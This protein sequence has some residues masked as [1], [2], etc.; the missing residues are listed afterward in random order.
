MTV[1]NNEQ[2]KLNSMAVATLLD[3]IN[4]IKEGRENVVEFE[5]KNH[6]ERVMED[7]ASKERLEHRGR[8]FTLELQ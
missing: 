2:S 4:N 8:R 5:V 1:Q 6:I 3:I 7:H